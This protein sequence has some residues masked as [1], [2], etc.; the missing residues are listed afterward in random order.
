[1]PILRLFTIDTSA[2]IDNST[3]IGKIGAENIVA[4][5][6]PLSTTSYPL[7]SP[8]YTI[9]DY[10]SYL[11][12]RQIKMLSKSLEMGIGSA[13]GKSVPIEIVERGLKWVVGMGRWLR[14]NAVSLNV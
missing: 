11:F 14:E 6:M 3:F 9:Y 4:G 5:R 13:G 7:P 10:H 2:F 8:G 1:M 12:R